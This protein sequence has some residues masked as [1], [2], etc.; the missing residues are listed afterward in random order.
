MIQSCKSSVV[1][2]SE[3]R[4]P[5]PRITTKLQKM[6]KKESTAKKGS[7]LGS[8]GNA[9][10]SVE[11]SKGQADLSL[12]DRWATGLYLGRVGDIV[13]RQEPEPTGFPGST[14]EEVKG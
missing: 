6:R 14:V 11:T 9:Q 3:V 8:A 5:S 1:P 4:H 13:D 10:M 12:R 2:S 7:D